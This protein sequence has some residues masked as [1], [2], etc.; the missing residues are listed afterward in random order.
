[1]VDFTARSVRSVKKKRASLVPAVSTVRMPTDQP[2]SLSE[3]EQLSKTPRGEKWW[4]KMN[5][6]NLQRVSTLEKL[7]NH[8]NKQP[9]QVII[10][11]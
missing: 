8:A 2:F 5:I 11:L 3:W 1:M 6:H 9:F 7:N 10:L 4:K